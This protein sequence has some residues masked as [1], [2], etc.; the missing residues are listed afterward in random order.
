M[1]LDFAIW[2]NDDD[3]RDTRHIQPVPPAWI[4][5]YPADAFMDRFTFT[6]RLGPP[7]L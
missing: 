7:I 2:P 4:A 3:L 5:S 6:Q 1:R